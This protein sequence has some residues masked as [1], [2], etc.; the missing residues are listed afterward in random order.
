[1]SIFCYKKIDSAVRLGEQFRV[2]REEMGMTLETAALLTHIPLKYLLA[3]EQ[4]QFVDLPKTKAHRLAYVKEY[5]ACLNLSPQVCVG[6]F[7]CEDGL[8]GSLL[9]HPH[10]AVKLFPFSSISTALRAIIL[11]SM[12]IFFASYLVWQVRRVLEPPQLAVYSPVE[13]HVLTQTRT[14]IAGETEKETHLTVNGQDIMVAEDGK[15][16]TMIDLTTGVNTITI[17]ATKKH[18]KTTTL[19]RHVV[20]KQTAGISEVSVR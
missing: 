19:T 13:G 6:Q 17:E 7:S 11:V 15:F 18:G 3:L 2:K 16:E 14:I 1:M 20:V 10:R 8:E 12:V 5:A 9:I 4:S